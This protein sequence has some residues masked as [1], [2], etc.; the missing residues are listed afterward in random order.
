LTNEF[1]QQLEQA[2][3]RAGIGSYE[4]LS[5]RLVDAGVPEEDATVE[6]LLAS[7]H[8]NVAERPPLWPDFWSGLVRVLD[9]D[10][11]TVISL[12]WAWTTNERLGSEGSGTT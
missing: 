9:L 4:E 12:M 3:D 10:R 1:R 7:T 2:M 11:D 5:E 8:S 6:T